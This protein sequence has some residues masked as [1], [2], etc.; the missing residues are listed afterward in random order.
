[1]TDAYSE[2]Q[3]DRG[4]AVLDPYVAQTSEHQTIQWL[5]GV[6]VRVLLDA[7]TTGG[8]FAVV[9]EVSTQPHATPLHLHPVDDESLLV[10][11]GSLR[12]WVGGDRYDVDQGGVAFLPRGV[13]HAFRVTSRGARLL[14]VHTPAGQEELFR[15][16]GWDLRQPLPQDWALAPE[17]IAQAGVSIGNRILGP[18]PTD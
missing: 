12:V 10:L 17:R 8:K 2:A 6:Q 5:E 14:V 18:P 9:E 7:A 15:Q 4:A 13:P 1:M 16:A 3:V 11:E